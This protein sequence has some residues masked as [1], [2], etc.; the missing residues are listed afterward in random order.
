MD[1]CGYR[2]PG[3]RDPGGGGWGLRDSEVRGVWLDPI[4]HEEVRAAGFKASEC[5]VSG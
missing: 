4:S 1:I 3:L 2:P 5:E